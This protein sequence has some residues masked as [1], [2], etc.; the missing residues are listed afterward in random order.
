MSPLLK[1]AEVGAKLKLARE[2]Q[3]KKI[4]EVASA[5]R[6]NLK[7]LQ[8]IDN[9]ILP[10]VPVIY[11]RAFIKSYAS[12]VGLDHEELL[13]ALDEPEPP[14]VIVPSSVPE[15]PARPSQP[16]FSNPVQRNIEPPQ[17]SEGENMFRR[18]TKILFGFAAIVVIGLVV[19]VYW[20]RNERDEKGVQEIS[21]ADVVKEQASKVQAPDTR[22]D[23]ARSV[24]SA[25]HATIPKEHISQKDSL[26]L[27]AV[28]SESVWVH[29]SVD[30][31][32]ANEYTFPPNYRMTW[33]ASDHFTI[34]LGNPGG[35]TFHLNGKSLGKLAEGKKPLKNMIISHE[36][37][38]SR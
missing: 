30:D 1:I 35:V 7:F 21:F 12:E 27:E 31:V 8:D 19:S 34:A 5:T 9:G 10:G 3:G 24:P 22:T 13:K 25:V 36:T 37:L 2:S 28:T 6:I 16:E 20:L 11:L 38:Q 17:R 15:K 18:Q 33:K 29:I 26:L 4:E 32:A 14:P 23:S